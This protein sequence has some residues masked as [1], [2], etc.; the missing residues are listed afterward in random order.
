MK[1][2]AAGGAAAWSV[3]RSCSG[4][5]QCQSASSPVWIPPR[6]L[7][8][9]FVDHS[10]CCWSLFLRADASCLLAP[11]LSGAAPALWAAS[12]ASF[13]KA[14]EVAALS[15]GLTNETAF[16]D[17]SGTGFHINGVKFMKLN[18]E[19]NAVIRGKAGENAASAAMSKK[20]III[21]VGKGSPQEISNAVEKMAA[22]LASKGF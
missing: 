13:I 4:W 2:E 19:L 11:S 6:W 16:N 1:H 12:S 18:S 10:N 21:G 9:R 22:D 15:K 7:L 8:H 3:H 5:R 14:D 17:L 20:A